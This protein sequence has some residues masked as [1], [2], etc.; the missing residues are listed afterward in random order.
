MWIIVLRACLVF[1]YLLGSFLII[2]CIEYK[3]SCNIHWI[4]S[5]VVVAV[6]WLTIAT[7]LLGAVLVLEGVLPLEKVFP[8]GRRALGVKAPRLVMDT[9]LHLAVSRH[10]VGLMLREAHPLEILM[11]MWVMFTLQVCRNYWRTCCHQVLT[12]LLVLTFSFY[13]LFS[14]M[15]CVSWKFWRCLE[16][17]SCG[18][19]ASVGCFDHCEWSCWRMKN[20]MNFVLVW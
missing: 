3:I 5:I 8:Q 2:S 18:C 6:V 13:N 17:C 7:P 14:G 4:F 15:S 10:V 12:F 16:W 11:V 1:D 20:F 9:H 19:F